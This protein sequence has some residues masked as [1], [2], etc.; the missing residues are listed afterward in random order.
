MFGR[1]LCLPVLVQIVLGLSLT[2]LAPIFTPVQA[3]EQRKSGFRVLQSAEL[4]AMLQKKDFFF[5]N[6]HIPYQ[7]EI[8][9]TDAFI[10]YDKIAVSLD[11]LPK[12]KNTPTVLYCLGGGMSEIAAQELVQ[13]G[14][15]RVSHLSGG[16]IEW[17]ESGYP[18][19][20]KVQE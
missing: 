5:V 9:D 18:I 15:L 12:D 17:K 20:N 10:P 4:D 3:E 19:I 7:G 13:L 11:K 16:M 1:C 8:R 2:G 6:V 14:Y